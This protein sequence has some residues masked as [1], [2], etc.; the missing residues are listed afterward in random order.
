MKSL[1]EEAA[2]IALQGLMRKD[3]REVSYSAKVN[4]K[5]SSAEYIASEAFEI[6]D[7]FIE[8]S[9]PKDELK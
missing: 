9:K 2:L 3:F 8:A 7:A 6:A 5:R 1:R 4:G